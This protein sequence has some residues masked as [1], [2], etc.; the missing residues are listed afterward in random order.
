[1]STPFPL[2]AE[3]GKILGEDLVSD[4]HLLYDYLEPY[5]EWARG[6]DVTTMELL[7][8]LK[9]EGIFKDLRILEVMVAKLVASFKATTQRVKR[10]YGSNAEKKKDL[11]LERVVQTLFKLRKPDRPLMSELVWLMVDARQMMNFVDGATQIQKNRNISTSV[12]AGPEWRLKTKIGED[13]K[14]RRIRNF[15]D[16]MIFLAET[17]RHTFLSRQAYSS[18]L[19][20]EVFK[21]YRWADLKA[22]EPGQELQYTVNNKV[23]EDLGL[24]ISLLPLRD[25]DRGV[26][27]LLHVVFRFNSTAP[28]PATPGFTKKEQLRFTVALS[29][30][31]LELTLPGNGYISVKPLFEAYG[32]GGFYE[33]LKAH[34]WALVKKGVEG[35]KLLPGEIE[36]VVQEDLEPVREQVHAEVTEQVPLQIDTKPSVPK[37]KKG[38]RQTTRNIEMADVLSTLELLGIS[39]QPGGSHFILKGPHLQ[40]GRE[41]SLAIPF[42][43]SAGQSGNNSSPYIAQAARV[44]GFTRREFLEKLSEI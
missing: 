26:F 5:E 15:C 13:A 6:G 39:N 11:A 40:T 33:N 29:R 27:E 25:G 36:E 21:K 9:E 31:H 3:D 2:D 44:F 30:V 22:A 19:T 34:V 20:Q 24:K 4:L 38:L 23:V 14:I 17:N 7:Q 42:K 37:Q 12:V 16:G 43:N 35:G 18:D 8:I 28:N 32:L 41:Q 1:M 10:L